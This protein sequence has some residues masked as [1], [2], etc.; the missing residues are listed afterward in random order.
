MWGYLTIAERHLRLCFTNRWNKLGLG[1][2]SN[3]SSATKFKE[4]FPDYLKK[5]PF[6]DQKERVTSGNLEIWDISVL[7]LLL[8]DLE[9]GSAYIE[10]NNSIRKIKDIRNLVAHCS[11]IP[12]L[13][14]NE[15][16]EELKSLLLGIGML[17]ELWSDIETFGEEKNPT[18]DPET[19]NMCLALKEQGNK[20]FSES[21]FE[22]AI[23]LYTEAIFRGAHLPLDAL[24]TL[25]LN[26]S[27]AYFR[28]TRAN[29]MADERTLFQKA[30]R[31]AMEA[32]RLTP[33]RPKP[34]YRLGMIYKSM[35]K[36]DKAIQELER[37]SGLAPT[38]KDIMRELIDCRHLRGGKR[39]G[40]AEDINYV[41]GHRFARDMAE[42]K[43]R[44]G[45]NDLPVSRNTGNPELDSVGHVVQA[46][47]YWGNNQL[48]FAIQ[49]FTRAAHL[50]N[51]EGMYNLGVCYSHGRG[52]KRDPTLALHWYKLASQ[53][54]RKNSFGERNVGVAEAYHSLALYALESSNPVQKQ[55]AVK[56]LRIA[57][58]DGLREAHNTLGTLYEHGSVVKQD[59]KKACE[60]NF[61]FSF[62]HEPRA[63]TICE[64]TTCFS[65]IHLTHSS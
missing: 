61:F 38:D 11:Y 21:S 26:R 15:R 28:L 39:R 37:A 33:D 41:P 40:E 31:D 8:C 57:S 34:F 58:E 19:A 46:Q 20:Y 51:P 24:A 16:S 50:G 17:E 9:W 13:D 14:F 12:E 5:L 55:E 48:T 47:K 42:L 4:Q 45:W 60:V 32:C 64:K 52:C 36:Y 29:N 54:P 22:R 30:K 65:S 23:D 2:W 1:V 53:K 6:R 43:T 62:C 27:S 10:E 3:V 49:E 7:F 35:E 59:F 25:Y 56:M 44:T 18:A 63:R